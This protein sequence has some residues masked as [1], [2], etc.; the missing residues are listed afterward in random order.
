MVRWYDTHGEQFHTKLV[1]LK[2]GSELTLLTGSA[3]LTRRN[4]GDLNLETDVL[5]TGSREAPALRS[6][7]LYFERLWGNH[8]QRFSV[9]GE[10]YADPSRWRYW[11]YRFQERSGLSSF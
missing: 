10:T 9:A 11:M 1:L 6:A 4:L 2:R 8:D 5:L 7:E 3:N